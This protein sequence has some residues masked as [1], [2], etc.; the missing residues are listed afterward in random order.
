MLRVV[1]L[2]LLCLHLERL[3]FNVVL[4]FMYRHHNESTSPQ[5]AQQHNALA[6]LAVED[7]SPCVA[8]DTMSLKFSIDMLPVHPKL[9]LQQHAQPLHSWHHQQ[10]QSMHTQQ[11]QMLRNMK[12]GR[13]EEKVYIAL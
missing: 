8:S 10:V 5:L 9:Q 3:S 13:V 2:Q 6:D 7:T 12:N 4:M 1:E 11:Q